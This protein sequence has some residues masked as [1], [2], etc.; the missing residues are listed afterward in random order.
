MDITSS[1][2]KHRFKFHPAVTQ[3]RREAHETIRDVCLMAAESLVIATGAASREQSIAITKLEEVMF[4]AN[5][6]VARGEG[7]ASTDP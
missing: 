6:A 1:E 2:L 5:A 7:P 4:W 3:N